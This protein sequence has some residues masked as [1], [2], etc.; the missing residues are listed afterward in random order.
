[1]SEFEVQA[2]EAAV[3]RP[4]R[5]ALLRPHQQVEEL[6]YPG[7]DHPEA[8]HVGGFLHGTMV[9]IATISPGPMPGGREPRAWQL[10]GI[11]VEHGQRGYG[12]GGLLLAACVAH[13]A[14]CGGRLVWC[15]A[16]VGS[17]G[18]YEHHGF[19]HDGEP[20]ELPNTGPHYRM[21]R[22]VTAQAEPPARAPSS[23][24]SP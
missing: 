21:Y 1:M 16:R 22:K 19:Y 24:G 12:V 6:V 13:A 7:D 11:A 15:N 9:G 20:F 4:L 14:A 10:R 8:L 18:F 3:V 5:R 2:V 23:S 17:S